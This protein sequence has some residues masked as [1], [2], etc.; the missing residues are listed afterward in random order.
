MDDYIARNRADW[1][2]AADEYEAAGE[3]S[4][5]G[6]A[7][8][9]I[10][11]ISDASLGIMP[12]DLDGKVVLEAGCGTAYVSAWMA[13]RGARPVGLD[14]SSRQLANAVKF[15]SRFGPRFPLVWGTAEAMP[16][17][18][19]LF[20]IVISEYGAALWS[21]PY[22]W[23][24]EAARVLRPGG[25]L[26]LLTNSV[27]VPMC[28]YDDEEVA[29]DATLKRPYFGMHRIEWSDDDG[30]EFHLNHGDW[31]RLLRANSFEVEDL[32]E[33]QVPPGSKTSYPWASAEWG[34]KWPIEEV[35]KARLISR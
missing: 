29:V 7:K 9:G 3:T 14:N 27:F 35:W 2:N 4:W 15:Q 5:Q 20:D 28:A 16:F 33:V 18:D 21:D 11:G 22:R 24:P 25:E 13:Q 10:Y 17:A 26:V 30:V 8:W 34:A 23:I 6:E 31:I 32:I 19:E 12:P 1:D